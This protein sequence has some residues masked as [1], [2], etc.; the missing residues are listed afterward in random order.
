MPAQFFL[1]S[2]TKRRMPVPLYWMV[3]GDR[4]EVE[5]WTPGATVPEIAREELVWYPAGAG[6]PFRLGVG[7]LFR[8]I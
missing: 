5:V 4:R 7:N 3:D 1:A 2:T 8:P 6:A